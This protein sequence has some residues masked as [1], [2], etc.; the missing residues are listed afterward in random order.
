MCYPKPGPRCSAHAMKRLAKANLALK[1]TPSSFGADREVYFKAKE[2]VAE[3]QKEYD[4]TP[5][6]LKELERRA[7]QYSFRAKEEYL[8][9]LTLGKLLREQQLAAIKAIDKGDLPHEMKHPESNY[10]ENQVK[11]SLVR[12]AIDKDSPLLEEMVDESS[13]WASKL[14]A[15]EIEAVSW[16]TSNGAGEVNSYIHRGP[17]PEITE[18]ERKQ[19]LNTITQLDSSFVNWKRENPIL[20]YRG[21]NDGIVSEGQPS[22]SWKTHGESYVSQNFKPG[23][24]FE[25][26]GFMS[27]SID[28]VK[29]AGFSAHSILMEIVSKKAAPVAAMSAWG[30]TER[31]MLL[32]RNQKYEVVRVLENVVIAG[33]EDHT[34]IQMIEL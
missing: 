33:R 9:R 14:T 27:T 31:E 32:P 26:K 1:N 5:A 20:V 28:P 19:I 17:R 21:I 6:G 11:T 25:S 24:I 3:A 12:N 29:A 23:S 8:T 30:T 22:E 34:L 2:E 7:A 18:D 13:A 15:D 10:G 4:S 16:F